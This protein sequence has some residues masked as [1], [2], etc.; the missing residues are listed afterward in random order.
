[1]VVAEV[2]KMKDK[3]LCQ[4]CPTWGRQTGPRSIRGSRSSRSYDECSWP[5]EAIEVDGA[6][7]EIIVGGGEMQGLGSGGY[8]EFKTGGKSS[9]VCWH[10]NKADFVKQD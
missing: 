10:C 2:A 8:F 3:I 5:W 4:I 7:L 1:M 9:A 6:S